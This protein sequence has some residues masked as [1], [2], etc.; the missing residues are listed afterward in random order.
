MT[1][2]ERNV[3][4]FQDT[5][6][7]AK[8]KYDPNEVEILLYDGTLDFA[9]TLALP[10]IHFVN[11]GTVS[12]GYK[13]AENE[14]VAILNFADG[15]TAGGLVE[16]G[17]T[18]QEENICRCSNLYPTLTREGCKKFYYDE[19]AKHGGVYTDRVIYSR[20]VTVFKDDV[21]YKTIFPRVLDVITCPAPS[22]RMDKYRAGGVYENRIKQILFSAIDNGA[23]TIILGAWGCGAFGQSPHLVA[24]AFAN[25]L[26]EYGGHFKHIVF[27]I[28]PTPMYSDVDNAYVFK[29]VLTRLYTGGVINE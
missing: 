2:R 11:G 1:D 3:Q 22:C 20:G 16:V 12:T 23:E 24:T 15:L 21:T 8:N 27:A 4:V 13:Y 9:R 14:H 6:L 25:V 10:P 29:E 18:T 17:E 26:C 7:Q 19:N 28:K 5:L